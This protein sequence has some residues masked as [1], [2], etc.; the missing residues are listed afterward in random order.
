M[1]GLS[2]S[3]IITARVVPNADKTAADQNS[4]PVAAGKTNKAPFT[5]KIN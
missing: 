2:G 1:V 3:P 5:L 4:S